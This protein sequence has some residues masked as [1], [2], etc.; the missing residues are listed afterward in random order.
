MKYLEVLSQKPFVKL[1]PNGEA[2]P[3]MLQNLR[4]I[5]I[6]SDCSNNLTATN[7]SVN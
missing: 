7:A 4:K 1:D 3:R 2:K 5:Q 6:S